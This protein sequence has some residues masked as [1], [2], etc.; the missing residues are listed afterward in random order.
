MARKTNIVLAVAL[1]LSGCSNSA[2]VQSLEEQVAQL[3]NQLAE[4]EDT[5]EQV[6][7]KLEDV[8]IQLHQV[9]SEAD[10][11]QTAVMELTD[12]VN[13]F[14]FEDWSMNVWDVRRAAREVAFTSDNL[15][16]SLE[17]LDYEVKE[18]KTLVDSF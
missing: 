2:Q 15:V 7:S 9:Q 14:N 13:D 4:M 5:L 1:L 16:A 11:L 18:L 6:Q 3:Q 8:Q 17:S 10:E 12:E